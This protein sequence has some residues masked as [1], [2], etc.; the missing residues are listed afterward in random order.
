MNRVSRPK[1]GP[2]VI[3]IVLLHPSTMVEITSRR[4]YVPL[5][6]TP[7]I[8]DSLRSSSVTRQQRRQRG[9]SGGKSLSAPAS[10]VVA[11]I[12]AAT[13][14]LQVDM[15]RGTLTFQYS[16]GARCS[17]DA[18]LVGRPRV[19]VELMTRRSE[20]RCFDHH[21][22]WGSIEGLRCCRRDTSTMRGAISL[23]PFHCTCREVRSMFPCVEPLPAHVGMEARVRATVCCAAW[24][25]RG[26]DS[27]QA[28]KAGA[29]ENSGASL[30]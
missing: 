30:A 11:T 9:P 14:N 10:V 1:S 8:Y 7:T 24:S 17:A 12:V 5:V 4:S 29:G 2:R 20:S 22:A 18:R 23:S 26:H 27:E 28:E 21:R 25:N 19:S 6:D 15:I 3:G 13:I 16:R